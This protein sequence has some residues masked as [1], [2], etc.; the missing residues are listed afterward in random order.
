MMSFD[1]T[2][3]ELLK[4]G[5]VTGG[6]PGVVM[7]MRVLA[8]ELA[9][10]GINVNC[11]ARGYIK[12]SS[13]PLPRASDFETALLKNVPWGRLGTPADVAQT[14]LLLASP[15]V[16]YVTGEVLAV[17]LGAFAGR[18]YLP[19]GTPRAA[20]IDGG[21]SSTPVAFPARSSMQFLRMR[22]KEAPG[23]LKE[24]HDARARAR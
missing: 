11:I 14:A 12:V 10:Q 9:E 2:R 15:A 17:N 3:R 6:A 20:L 1:S 21:G 16:D 24:G 22:Q 4:L 19:L 7:F 23:E 5:A 18:M 8:I 13:G